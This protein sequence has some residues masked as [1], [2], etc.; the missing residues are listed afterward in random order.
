MTEAP[1]RSSIRRTASW[2]DSAVLATALA[3]AVA[4]VIEYG[5]PTEEHPIPRGLLEA[6]ELSAVAMFVLARAVTLWMAPA[7]LEHLR[8]DWLDYSL[9]GAGVAALGI[10]FELTH[11]P[12]FK[13]GTIYIATMQVMI[14]ARSGVALLRFNLAFSQTKLHPARLMVLSF[15]AAIV[16][17]TALLALP[18]ASRAAL[19]GDQWYYQARHLLNCLFT[20]T[21]ATCVTGLIVY[22]TGQDFTLFG[23]VVILVLIQL[24]GLG[25]MIFGSVFGLML[26]RQLSLRESLVLQD[27]LSHE[28]LGRIGRMV[29]FIC[30]ATFLVESVGALMLYPMWD[31]SVG[32]AADR[33][34]YSIFHAVSAFCNAG[35]ALQHDSL[36]R[37]HGVWQVYG[38]V[39]PLIVLGGLGFPV[40]LNLFEVGRARAQ[41]RWQRWRGQ[42][43]RTP[44]YGAREN[45]SLH[46]KLVLSTTGILIVVPASWLWFFETPTRLGSRHRVLPTVRIV[47]EAAPESM[48]GLSAGQRVLAALFQSVTARTAGFNTVRTDA[49]ALTPAS[50]FLMCMLMFIGGSPG[51]TAGG[52][53]TVAFAVLV[54][55]VGAAL[56]RRENVEAFSRS[57]PLRLVEQAATLTILMLSLVG[58]VT[59]VLCATEKAPMSELMF[60]SFSAC[61]TVGLSMGITPQLT[62]VGRVVIIVAMF[63]GRLGP[64]TVLIALA[65]RVQAARY[66]YP[67]EHVVIG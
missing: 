38:V 65:G 47:V 37:Y 23:Q 2:L 9:I 51:S 19:G 34:F 10:E 13:A 16:L 56:R 66:E 64:L 6:I 48:T 5:F 22:D 7:R 50:H 4:L 49:D 28:T 24:G 32:S 42:P 58:F 52:M 33:W 61:G 1:A 44:H 27:A 3:A 12:V 18:A 14:L 17:G 15:T 40:L 21:S 25:I 8:R 60:E 35:F 43:G 11:Q 55:S 39:M 30:I 59:L 54:L 57:I 46:G 29:K 36:I 41:G 45:L 67:E 63:A 20:A 26:G 53:K 62:S 31:Q